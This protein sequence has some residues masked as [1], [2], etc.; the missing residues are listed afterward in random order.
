[1]TS[2][3]QTQANSCSPGDVLDYLVVTDLTVEGRGL[4]RHN[5][6]V[7]FL[8]RGLPGAHVSARVV[9][10]KKRVIEAVVLEVFQHSPHVRPLWCPH[11]EEC[12]ACLWQHCSREFELEWKRKRIEESFFRIGKLSDIE[13][14]AV[15]PS[16]KEREYRNK[17]AY[18]FTKAPE[19]GGLLLGLRK[20]KEHT[21]VEVTECGMQPAPAMDI[22]KHVRRAAKRLGLAAWTPSAQG[23]PTGYLRF[24]V[25][26]TPE[27]APAGQQQFFV[28][29]ITGA[30]HDEPV[31][32]YAE[33]SEKKEFLSQTEAVRL[34]GEELIRAF[35]LTGFAHLERKQHSNVAQGER[36]IRQIGA[37]SYEERFGELVLTVP[38]NVFLQTNTGA[39][40]LL[41]NLIARE[42]RLDG[43]QIVWDIYSGIGSIAL[44]LAPQAREV[45]CLEI[46]ADAVI[47]AQN[48]SERL[49]FA[50]CFFYQG[51]LTPERTKSV[52][53]ADV[54]ILD[55]PRA[56]LD[57]SALEALRQ[58]TADRILYVSC[59]AGT[60]AR[61]LAELA[62]HWKPIRCL[63]VDMFPNTPHVESLVVLEPAKR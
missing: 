43:S 30:N 36:L 2:A 42:A 27:Y 32:A 1:M 40:S 51:V 18:A 17:M 6:M 13:I 62:R 46:Q 48:N 14:S 12:G 29:C 5:G 61:D 56:G 41:Y 26:H 47:A 44:Y 20:R 50:N 19:G 49:G 59:D 10:V 58:T 53:K 24:L 55:P 60:Q 28:E 54:I 3:S 37:S 63:P 38:H 21:V 35:K 23:V 52:P 57:N 9:Q 7:V 45:Y 8:D 39:A 22:L 31:S 33:H 4:A 15:Q 11:A 34:L 25:I 16:P